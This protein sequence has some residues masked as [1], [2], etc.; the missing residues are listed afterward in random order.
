M[1]VNCPECYRSGVSN[2]GTCPGCGYNFIAAR[3]EEEKAYRKLR[4]EQIDKEWKEDIN[5]KKERQRICSNSSRKS[6]SI[7]GGMCT[8]WIC[9]HCGWTT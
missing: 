5:A 1:L 8:G 4:A 2:M 6:Y 7:R 9:N 3:A